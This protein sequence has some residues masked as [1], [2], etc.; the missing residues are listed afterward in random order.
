MKQRFTWVLLFAACVLH[1]G[2]APPLSAQQTEALG[3]DYVAGDFGRLLY[4]ENGV[5]VRRASTDSDPSLERVAGINAPIFPGDSVITAFDQ[6][7]EIQLAGGTLVRIDRATDVTFL[8]MP[9][10]YADVA[11]NTVLQ[12][13]H[14]AMR[15]NALLTSDSEFRVDTPAASVFLSEDADLRVAVDEDGV[16]YVASHRGVVDV[17]VGER[18]VLLRSGT[19]TTI[20]P[21][22]TP[23]AP[24]SFNTLRGDSF[25]RWVAKRDAELRENE[26]YADNSDAYDEVPDEVRPYYRE[27]SRHGRWVYAD[28]YGWVWYPGDVGA[29]WRPYYDGY[30]TYGSRGYFWVSYRPWGWAPFHYGRWGYYGGAWCWIPG[31]VFGGAWVAWSWGSAYI[32]WS[33]LGYWNTAYCGGPWAYSYGYYGPSWSF[34]GYNHFHYHSYHRYYVDYHHIGKDYLTH[35]A[36]V[37]RPPR[38]HPRDLARS[39]DAR[40]RALRHVRSDR[41]AHLRSVDQETRRASDN[42]RG[43]ERRLMAERGERVRA[44]RERTGAAAAGRQRVQPPGSGSRRDGPVAADRDR[45]GGSNPRATRPGKRDLTTNDGAGG[46]VVRRGNGRDS[47]PTSVPGRKAARPADTRR[48]SGGTTT[49]VEG[50]E[51]PRKRMREVYESMSS[52]RSTRERRGAPAATRSSRS[53]SG[54]SRP[55]ATPSRSSG[56]SRPKATPSRSSGGS[57][58]KATPGRS[59]GGSRPK[60]TPGR[61]SGG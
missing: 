30:W 45:L 28:E 42:L 31:R 57:R 14:G 44:M 49:R 6:R 48:G 23:E 7:A 59:S 38:A 37:T 29:D 24:V 1:A 51:T 2:A 20:Y 50:G 18:S 12:V 41:V 34:I 26:R 13:E 53:G 5:T 22:E 54:G 17:T 8:S 43:A 52:P 55:K 33:P 35:S 3:D 16:T 39:A 11:D 61:S 21:G 25:D 27:L 46:G 40:E 32:G 60:A 36:V 47:T 56:G 58:P 4:Q 19:K 9:D 15:I 10:P